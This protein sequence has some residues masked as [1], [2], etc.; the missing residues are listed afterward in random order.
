MILAI[1]GSERINAAQAE[2]AARLIEELFDR[3]RPAKVISG[4]AKGVDTLVKIAAERR[5]IEFQGYPPAERNWERGFKPRNML[6]AQH[7]THLVRLVKANPTT[8]GS[9]WTRDYAKH[10]GKTTEEFGI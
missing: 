9:G 1:V 10:L 8:Y 3:Y 5:G 4:E 2:K 7:C 6:I